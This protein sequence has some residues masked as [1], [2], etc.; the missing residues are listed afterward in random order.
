MGD[1]FGKL[2]AGAISNLVDMSPGVLAIAN[3]DA[4]LL[5]LDQKCLP[6]EEPS[7]TYYCPLLCRKF[8]RCNS[9]LKAISRTNQRGFGRQGL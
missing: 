2:L 8:R 3:I 1:E 4:V 9:R 7:R 6:I 5:Q